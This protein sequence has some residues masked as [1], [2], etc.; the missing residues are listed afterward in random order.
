MT[1][2]RKALLVAVIGAGGFAFSAVTASAEIVCNGDTCWH[3]HE[4]YDYPAE[5]HLVVHPDDWH[6]G[7]HEHYAMH[8]HDGHGYWHGDKW[9]DMDH[10]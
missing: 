10:H 4:H 3:V 1:S 2:L 7:T 5:A 9:I 6:W 8:E